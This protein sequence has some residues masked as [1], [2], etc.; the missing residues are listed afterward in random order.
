MISIP[1][2]IRPA[3]F[4]GLVLFVYYFVAD[5][6]REVEASL[7]GAVGPHLSSSI[8]GRGNG[9]SI[10][11]QTP[12]DSF[13]AGIARGCSSAVAIAVLFGI[14]W[15]FMTGSM[16][17][18]TRAALRASTFVVV[19]NLLRMILI[20]AIGASSGPDVLALTHDVVGTA[21]SYI[22]LAVGLGILVCS[23]V[24]DDRLRRARPAPVLTARRVSL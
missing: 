2:S 10:L 13:A 21:L 7:L 18:R 22:A 1:F 16:W 14:G 17:E 6:I 12:S 8:V 20:I 4:F 15:L 5:L 24:L 9:A 3:I 23:S 11:V 19:A